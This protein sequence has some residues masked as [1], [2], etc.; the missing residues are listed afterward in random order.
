MGHLEGGRRGKGTTPLYRA[1]RKYG[2]SAFELSILEESSSEDEAYDGETY[3]VKKFR[4]SGRQVFNLNDGGKGNFSPCPETL[5]KM[6]AAQKGKK[7]SVETRAKIA[8]KLRG[9]KLSQETIEKISASLKGK[10]FT[11]EALEKIREGAKK[12]SQNPEWRRKNREALRNTAK[13]PETRKKLSLKNRSFSDDDAKEAFILYSQGSKIKDLKAK[14][15]TTNTTLYKMLRLGADLLGLEFKMH[16]Q[17]V[18]SLRAGVKNPVSFGRSAAHSHHD[19][20]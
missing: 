20:G 5:A 18:S 14:Y 16:N 4:H 12:R 11:N 8:R 13:N 6:S 19:G 9:T 3:W 2:A 1:I 10:K 17:K 7:F 15:Q